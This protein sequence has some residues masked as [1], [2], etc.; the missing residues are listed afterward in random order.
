[1]KKLLKGVKRGHYVLL[2]GTPGLGKSVLAVSAIRD[3]NLIKDFFGYRVF[4]INA[5]EARTLIDI[6]NIQYRLGK[7]LDDKFQRDIYN[8]EEQ[9]IN[10]MKDELKKI[11]LKPEFKEALLVL[12]DVSCEEVISAFEFG[13]KILVTTNKRTIVPTECS[14]YY[15]INKGFTEKES[16]Q[17]FSKSI[18]LP[19]E[20]IPK[21]AK[22]IHERCKGAPMVIKLIGSQLEQYKEEATNS[23]RWKHYVKMIT[24][25]KDGYVNSIYGLL[26]H[27][28]HFLIFF[29][30]CKSLA[31]GV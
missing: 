22:I 20:K 18:N 27:F 19:V 13:C 16:L 5:G 21:E 31:F 7:I 4:F 1:M 8:T 26:F 3:P 24:E 23:E 17:F 11:F 29:C 28:E 15:D 10:L 25:N 6:A 2:V 14:E 12:D 30:D 9:G